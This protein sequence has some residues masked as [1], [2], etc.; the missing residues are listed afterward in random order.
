MIATAT[1]VLVILAGRFTQHSR[2]GVMVLRTLSYYSALTCNRG[3]LPQWPRA[4]PYIKQPS[5]TSS[6][7]L[8]LLPI[9]VLE[10]TYEEHT[11]ILS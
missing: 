2:Q 1:A 4:H 3:R 5:F 7:I 10:V 8:K 9:Y 6:E 11:T